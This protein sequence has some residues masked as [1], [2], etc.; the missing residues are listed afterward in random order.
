MCEQVKEEGEGISRR[1]FL[2]RTGA[3]VAGAA[4]AGTGAGAA[5]AAEPDGRIVLGTGEHRY[6]CVHDWLKPPDDIRW[7]DTHGVA[8]DSQGRIYIAHTVH[9]TSAKDDAIVV[10]D[11]KGRFLSSFGARFKGGA[12]GLDLRKEGDREYLYHCDI[13]HKQ[14]VKTTLEG[15]VVWE[16]GA[17]GEAGVYRG[18]A[19][20]VPTNVA[21]SPNGDFYVTDGYGSDYIHQYTLKGDYVRTFGGKGKEPGR[22]LNAHGIW[23]DTRGSEPLLAVAD[24]G[25]SR[26]QYLTLEG[27]HVR[28]VTDG[29]RQPCHFHFRGELMLVPDLKSVVTLLDG[30][31]KVVAALGDGDPS[32]LRDHPRSDFLPGKFVHPHSAKFLHNGDI[33]V[34]EWVPIG[35]VTLLRRLKA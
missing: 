10:F 34:V 32:S 5:K 33:L 14:V 3:A 4:I 22:V 12:H 2:A 8:Q 15:Q 19:P 27:K 30:D 1:E 16:K 25:N 21:F 17:P 20:F 26:I 24:R 6:E 28:F 35:R 9:P 13:A 7:G 18:G 31:N 11:R 23:L 29:M